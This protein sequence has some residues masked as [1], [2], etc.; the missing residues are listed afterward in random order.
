MPVAVNCLLVFSANVGSVG[1]IEMDMS[2]APEPLVDA[3]KLAV[4]PPLPHPTRPV[5]SNDTRSTKEDFLF[6]I[7]YSSSALCKKMNLNDG[8][9]LWRNI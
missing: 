7:L 9:S 8:D 6:N 4:P 1:V 2:C 3:S 5:M